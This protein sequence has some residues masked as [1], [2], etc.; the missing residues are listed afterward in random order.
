VRTPQPGNAWITVSFW[1]Y[2]SN[3]PGKPA[4]GDEYEI[5]LSSVNQLLKK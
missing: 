4:P 3:D 1:L 5:I 2:G